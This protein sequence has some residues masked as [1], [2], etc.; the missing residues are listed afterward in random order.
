M[1]DSE[2]VWELWSAESME[3]LKR[4][5]C[6]VINCRSGLGGLNPVSADIGRI[7]REAFGG[8]THRETGGTDTEAVR[9]R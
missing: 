1:K 7:L 3:R 6:G 9:I 5:G 4:K 2:R 8:S